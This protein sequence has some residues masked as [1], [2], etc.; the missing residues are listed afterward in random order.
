[1]SLVRHAHR[2]VVASQV[3]AAPVPDRSTPR[4]AATIA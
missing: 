2:T 4:L 1:M 3:D